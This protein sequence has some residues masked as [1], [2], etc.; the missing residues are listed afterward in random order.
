MRLSN[1]RL[2]NFR[3]YKELDVE[4]PSGLIIFSGENAQG[5]SNILEAIYCLAITKSSRAQ[6]DKEMINFEALNEGIFSEIEATV[7]RQ[8]GPM[9]LHLTL[10]GNLLQYDQKDSNI[11]RTKKHIRIN[12]IPHLASKAVG[13]VNAVLFSPDD[14]EV[15]LGSP[16]SRR[17][18]LDILLSQL[19]NEYLKTLQTYHHILS[20]RNHLL[21]SIRENRANI[22][23]LDFWDKELC[24][25]GTFILDKR[26]TCVHFLA[27]ES[28]KTYS[29]LAYDDESLAITYSPSIKVSSLP[30][31]DYQ[32][33]FS[34]HLLKHRL[35]DIQA[36]ITLSGPHRDDIDICINEH[37][38]STTAS[39][40]QARTAVL[41]LKLS[42]AKFLAEH[43]LDEP[44]LLLDDALS[45]LDDSRK[46]F[47]LQ[48][49]SK[50][51]QV[52]LTTIGVEKT[53]ADIPVA[54]SYTIKNGE[55]I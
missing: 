51:K 47:L 19:S 40:G 43:R 52:F 30:K 11:P 15:I 4:F 25:A 17:R 44:I 23:E 31:E 54:A 39:R 10:S 50:K 12:G 16:A 35:R 14:I 37:A 6:S 24:K 53:S 5:K 42:E 8:D 26:V 48:E 7:E 22:E 27:E 28:A 3:N 45:E 49:I 13:K 36:G 32:D 18:Y 1:L 41:A 33:I 46:L 55:L 29:S 20:Q 34:E 9:T 2:K 21:R 38:L